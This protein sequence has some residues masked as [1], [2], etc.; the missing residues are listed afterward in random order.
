MTFVLASSS[1]FYNY[2]CVGEGT[3]FMSSVRGLVVCRC[4]S[5]VSA[6]ID[7]SLEKYMVC[8]SRDNTLSMEV[9][10]SIVLFQL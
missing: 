3:L 8:V 5:I 6:V 9:G 10:Q 2:Y 4:S 7:M 1:F